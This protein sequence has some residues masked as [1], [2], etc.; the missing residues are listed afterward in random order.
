MDE[1]DRNIQE[2][3]KREGKVQISKDDFRKFVANYFLK[4]YN[5]EGNF[6]FATVDYKFFDKEHKVLDLNEGKLVNRPERREVSS[7][8]PF[9]ITKEGYEKLQKLGMSNPYEVK[10]KIPGLIEIQ[11]LY[12]EI[13]KIV[14]TDGAVIITPKIMENILRENG[15]TDIF[16][17]HYNYSMMYQPSYNVYA[18]QLERDDTKAILTSKQNETVETQQDIEEDGIDER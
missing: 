18:K 10:I 8:I 17:D 12:N 13:R 6:D 9:F 4:H 2:R 3:M 15:Y 7:L 16:F 1:Q 11:N 14:N 5:L